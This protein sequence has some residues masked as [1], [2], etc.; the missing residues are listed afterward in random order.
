MVIEWVKFGKPS[1]V[2]IV[3]SMV[4]G[5]ATITPG[6]GFVGPIGGVVYV[7]LAGSVCYYYV[8]LIK[9]A[10]KVDDP[11][12]VFPVHGVGGI[13]GVVLV[14]I[15]A[16][17]SLGGMGY[18]DSTTMSRQF[19]VQLT[20]TT[21]VV[22]WSGIITFFIIEFITILLGLRVGKEG[23]TEGPDLAEHGELGYN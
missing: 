9:D 20:G 1:L 16:T 10:L 18:A 6:S 3:M 8:N 11:L 22:A 17:T 15:F 12:D 14:L 21:A 4:A 7:L 23:E 19:L 5:L 2:G 13:L